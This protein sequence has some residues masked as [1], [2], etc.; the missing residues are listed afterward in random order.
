MCTAISLLAHEHYFGRTLDLEHTYAEAVTV[1]PRR[2]PFS[3]RANA[4]D[5]EHHA[6]IGIA[7][8][9]DGYPLY[10]DAV[11]EHGLCMAGLN[12][13]GNAVYHP[14]RSG[15]TNL[16]QFELIPWIL[17]KCRT[18]AEA[19]EALERINL[20]DQSF[21]S[22]LPV[23][24]L[25]WIISD[26]SGSI[27]AEPM[28]EGIMIYDDPVSILTN[29]PPFPFQ[30]EHLTLYR[31][32][33]A[34]TEDQKIFQ[35]P[36]LPV[37]SRGMG[38]MG[39]PGDWSSPSRFVRAAFVKG[40]ARVPNQESAAVGQ[41]FHILGTVEQVEGCVAAENGRLVRT[42]YTS[43]CNAD[44]GVYYYTS[45]GNHTITAVSMGKENLDGEALCVYPLVT[46]ESIRWQN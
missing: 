6:I 1:T 25:H 20:T 35:A 45:Y 13:V 10:Y 46:Q 16:T 41:F 17:G 15:M 22:D 39:L 36:A 37:C 42:Q 29:N 27:V 23:P 43:C 12:F 18:V 5:R 34:A 30:M 38:A 14:H 31:R 2:F 24:Q 33:S 3:Y 7:T 32:V 44:R 11:N 4:A 40:N 8:V 9:M 21:R 19:R 26:K 28:Q